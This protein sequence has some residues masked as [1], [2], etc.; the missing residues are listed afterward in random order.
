MDIKQE[1][2]IKSLKHEQDLVAQEFCIRLELVSG[3]LE[4]HSG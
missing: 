3:Y 2:Q 4:L 1:I